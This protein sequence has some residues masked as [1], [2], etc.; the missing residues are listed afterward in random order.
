MTLLG[1]LIAVAIIIL[2]LWIVQTYMPPPWKTP[3]LVIVVVLALCFLVYAL[4][5]GAATVRV[6]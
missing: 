5:P 6:R 4:W 1:L 3:T 2:A